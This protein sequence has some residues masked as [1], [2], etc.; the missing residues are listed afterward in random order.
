MLG[1][2]NPTA[3]HTMTKS[4]H[5]NKETKKPKQVRAAAPPPAATTPPSA[6]A[7]PPPRQRK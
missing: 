5:G 6:P 7:A 2:P 1:I 4:R 3:R